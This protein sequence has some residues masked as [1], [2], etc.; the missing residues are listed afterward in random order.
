MSEALSVRAR[1]ERFP[2]TVKGAFILRGEDRDPHQVRVLQARVVAVAGR[3]GREVPIASATLDA[4]PHRDVFVPFELMVADLEPGWYDL[5]LDLEVDGNPG[6]FSGGRRFAVPWPRATVRRGQIRVDRAIALGDRATATVDHV[7]CGGDSLRLSVTVQP[8][9]PVQVRLLA[10]G[11][12]L[13]I[14][15]TDADEAAGRTRVPAYPL[16]RAHRV[17]RIELR[18]RGRG[19]EGAID[20]PLD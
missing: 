6:T 13:E 10:D 3:A 19:V 5:E 15:E 16:L 4:A 8:P 14:L 7:D 20:V 11:S 1:F 12:R 17:L 9:T 18:G 2:A